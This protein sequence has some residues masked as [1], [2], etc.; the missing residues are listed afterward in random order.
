MPHLSLPLQ[1]SLARWSRLR[2]AA[3]SLGAAPLAQNAILVGCGAGAALL[4]LLVDLD[5]HLPG[6]AILRCVAPLALGLAIVPRRFA[7]SVMGGAALATVLLGGL[8]SGAPGW[9]SAT[10]LV[11]TGPI[12]DFL[13]ARARSGR[14]LYA[15]L[16][17]G[18]LVANLVAFSVR[19]GAKVVLH[20]GGNP[21][22]TWWPRAIVTYSLCGLAAGLVSAVL[23][24]R[25][26][27]PSRAGAAA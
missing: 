7:G 16:A 23:W 8:A 1:D 20:D 21:L 10:S 4:T 19:L 17:L 3:A 14:A 6:H 27:G 9:G 5:V 25:F 18:G 2:A 13:S 22:A 15:A 11:L 24:F 12:L 26:G